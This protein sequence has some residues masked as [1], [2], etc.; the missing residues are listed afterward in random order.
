MEGG[1]E[2]EEEG[3]EEGEEEREEGGGRREGHSHKTYV[4]G[5]D[6]RSS[7]VNVLDQAFKCLSLPLGVTNLHFV[8]AM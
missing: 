1:K 4:G 8:A 2:G 5:S 6:S 7:S 3:G